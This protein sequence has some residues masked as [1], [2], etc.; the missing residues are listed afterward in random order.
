MGKKGPEY[1]KAGY[2][3]EDIIKVRSSLQIGDV[4]EIKVR[5]LDFDEMKLEDKMV[6]VKVTGIFRRLA[7]VERIQKGRNRS[8][9]PIM[10]V[11][12][13]DFFDGTARVV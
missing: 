4:L 1:I 6:L 3:V 2:S 12:Y 9:Y 8:P 7:S 11:N 13:K 5:D 10:T